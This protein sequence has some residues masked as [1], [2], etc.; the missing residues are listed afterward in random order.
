M[1]NKKLK[2]LIVAGLLMITHA[3]KD[4]V[5]V[6]PDNIAKIED[7]FASRLS[8]ERFLASLYGHIPNVISFGNRNPAAFPDDPGLAAGDEIWLNDGI[9]SSNGIAIPVA[10]IITGGQ[11]VR[12]PHLDSWGNGSNNLFVA[13]RDCNIFLENIDKPF[14]LTESEKAYWIGEAKFLKAYFHY[15]LLRMYGPVPIIRENID[16]ASGLEAVRVKRDPV[17]EVV[18]YIVELLDEAMETLPVVVLDEETELGK[19]TKSVAASI[20][21]KTLV[22]A[23][24]PLFNGNTDYSGFQNKDGQQLVST[25]FDPQKWTRAE[26]A[27][28]Q[29]INL[30]DEAGRELYTTAIGVTITPQDDWSDTT[31]IKMDI[32]GS[33]TD[34]WNKELIWG[35]PN[36]NVASLQAASRPKLDIRS[37]L[38]T[39]ANAFWAPTMRIAEMFYSENGVPINEDVSY[40]YENRFNVIGNAGID[41]KHYVKTGFAAPVL[42]L[43]REP[44]FYA[45]IGFDGG[46]W[47][48]DQTGGALDEDG[49]HVV[50][51]K[52]GGF[53]SNNGPGFSW[54]ETGFFAKKLSHPKNFLGAQGGFSTQ[55]YAFPLVRL[56]DLFLLYAEVLNEVGKTP[57][58]HIWIDKVRERAGLN[59]VVA[60][61][62]AHS[63]NPSKPNT[64]DGFREIVQHERM[65]ELVFEGHRFWDLRRWKRSQEFMNRDIRGWNRFGSDTEQY[66]KVVTFATAKF[67]SR[68]YLWPIAEGDIIRN[69]NLVQNPGW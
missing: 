31:R 25:T 35:K 45:S 36:E 56:A 41:H 46:V 51:A 58:A 67:L 38:S 29:A 47:L 49:A 8:A 66:Y 39:G 59:G 50:D 10:Q 28:L 23:A 26:A 27:C 22:L 55:R 54:S 5:D 69:P 11:N 20:K 21:A 3:C 63:S 42:H 40:D 13:L 48:E 2:I 32:R 9:R 30:A 57:E 64:Q 14:D 60:S 1:K 17:D 24:S 62:M 15:F 12:S 18:D 16:V 37:R 65:I 19:A 44:R 52:L 34:R 6:V 61:W 53:A 68:D 33:I 7:A 43:N 4:F